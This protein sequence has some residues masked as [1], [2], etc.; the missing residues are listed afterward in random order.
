LPQVPVGWQWIDGGGVKGSYWF[1][2]LTGSSQWVHPIDDFIKSTLSALRAPLKPMSLPHMQT[3][4]GHVTFE[5]LQKRLQAEA[6][7]ATEG[8]D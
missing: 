8:K 7:A 3:V 5:K 4:F 1:N 2:E 6:A